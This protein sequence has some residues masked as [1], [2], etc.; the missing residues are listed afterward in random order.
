MQRPSPK[1]LLCG[2][3]L[4][5]AVL[6][7]GNRAFASTPPGSFIGADQSCEPPTETVGS[8][9]S[10]LALSR[11][12]KPIRARRLGSGSRRIV[13]LGRIHGNEPEGS[14]ATKRIGDQFVA[15]N[16]MQTTTLFLIEDLNP[17]GSSARTRE[18]A[19]G[20]DLNRNFPARNFKAS[21]LHG[22]SATSEPES[23]AL[24]GVLESFQPDLVIALHSHSNA[25]GINYDGPAKAEAQQ[26]SKLSGLDVVENIDL[27]AAGHPGSLGQW[28]GLD[29]Q[30]KILTVEYTRGSSAEANWDQTSDALLDA[31][32]G[33]SLTELTESSPSSPVR[34]PLDTR[35]EGDL[36]EQAAPTI[37]TLFKP[38][39]SSIV[40]V[41][42]AETTTTETSSIVVS[43]EPE[44]ADG[45]NATGADNGTE[46]TEISVAIQ[47]AKNDGTPLAIAGGVGSV[48]FLVCLGWLNR[49]RL[50]SRT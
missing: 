45:S 4:S 41:A 13:W 43:S 18:N 37:S 12:G 28:W 2:T 46:V 10:T 6:V 22:P 24:V 1:H 32:A 26:F 40:P 15:K 35:P 25:Q 36:E 7:N 16:L 5:F 21:K 47:Q 44:R 34:G 42:S 17:D 23:C 33:S 31:I 38:V 50:F 11:K 9:W 49:K 39:E 48:A 8:Q 19:N 14:E 29:N 3:L 30:R 20:V 27:D